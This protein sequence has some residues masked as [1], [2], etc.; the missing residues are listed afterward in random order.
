MEKPSRGG[1]KRTAV[2]TSH[3]EDRGSDDGIAPRY[4]T[5]EWSLIAGEYVIGAIP[6][7]RPRMPAMR[8][9]HG[10]EGLCVWRRT[11]LW[12]FREPS[13]WVVMCAVNYCATRGSIS[14]P[15]IPATACHQ[16]DYVERCSRYRKRQN[17]AHQGAA[18]FS[19]MKIW[20]TKEQVRGPT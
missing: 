14:P 5:T 2:W 6:R 19:A 18:S 12:T 7:G 13:L 8:L 4:V 11:V 15:I 17:M 3:P 20:H 9:P 10:C 16:R 1:E